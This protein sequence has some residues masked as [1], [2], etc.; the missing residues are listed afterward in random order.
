[1]SKG[2]SEETDGIVQGCFPISIKSSSRESTEHTNSP[3]KI[4]QSS[5]SFKTSPHHPKKYFVHWFRKGLRLSDN[6]VLLR[7]SN[8]GENQWRIIDK[9]DLPKYPVPAI[10]SNLESVVTTPIGRNHDKKNLVTFSKGIG[11]R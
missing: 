4:N 2:E 9:N 8:V 3:K 6:P 10:S 7:G 5:Y 1:M 11:F